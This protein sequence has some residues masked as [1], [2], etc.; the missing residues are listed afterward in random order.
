MM[1]LTFK[2][3]LLF[4]LLTSTLTL[5]ADDEEK[6]YQ[7]VQYACTGVG[8]AKDEPKWGLYAAK[9]MF[10]TAGRA[11]VS[12]VQVVIKDSGGQKVFE[13]DCDSPWLVMN[14]KPGTYQVTA[15]ALKKYTKTVTMTVGAGGKQTELAIR[16]P[17]I[18]G[19]VD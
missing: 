6:T 15:T 10:T 7:G 12:Y 8:D 4:V 18:K 17:E 3:I 16:F 2:L 11:Y 9:L 13:A 19:G 5:H 14:L 1:K